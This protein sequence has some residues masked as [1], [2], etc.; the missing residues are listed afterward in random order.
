M[1]DLIQSTS[2]NDHRIRK[3]AET[4][5]LLTFPSEVRENI[6]SHLIGDKLIH[7]KYLSKDDASLAKKA[8]KE[9]L[10]TSA[11][12]R[13][14]GKMPIHFMLNSD[15]EIEVTDNGEIWTREPGWFSSLAAEV[16]GRNPGLFSRS[17]AEATTHESR[18][19]SFAEAKAAGRNPGL[20]S[21]PA[22]AAASEAG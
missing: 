22:E 15:D 21:S 1:H 10:G 7:L 2:S 5:P 20:F 9:Y 8:E 3:N 14:S 19:L 13:E 16:A 6:L 18:F 12:G 17:P 4:S 11:N